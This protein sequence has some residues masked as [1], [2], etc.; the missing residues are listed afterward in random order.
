MDSEEFQEFDEWVGF[1]IANGWI[2]PSYCS[3][4]D[5][6]YLYFTPEEQEEIEEGG[7]PCEPVFRIL[8]INDY[9]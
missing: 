6:G 3:T 2:S 5:G 7:D 8:A 4:H 1:G 9:H